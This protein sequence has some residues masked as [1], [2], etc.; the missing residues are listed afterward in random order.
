MRG[1]R[2]FGFSKV[3]NGFTRGGTDVGTWI[4][5]SILQ[6]VSGAPETPGCTLAAEGD[7]EAKAKETLGR[8]YQSSA[9]PPMTITPE[10]SHLNLLELERVLSHHKLL[11]GAAPCKHG[12]V[13]NGKVDAVSYLREF[14]ADGRKGVYSSK[15][16]QMP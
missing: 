6:I 11:P 14:L 16:C 13:K 7:G 5:A 10:A 3:V 9:L 12:A 4:S 15:F 1:R 8:E 2:A